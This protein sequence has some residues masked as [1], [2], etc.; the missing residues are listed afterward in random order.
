MQTAGHWFNQC[1]KRETTNLL[2]D[3]NNEEFDEGIDN[4]TLAYQEDEGKFLGG[5][6]IVTGY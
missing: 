1:P 4:T 2:K 6:L 3:N 5:S